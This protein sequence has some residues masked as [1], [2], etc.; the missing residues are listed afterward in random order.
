MRAEAPPPQPPP[1]T[2]ED[3][4]QRQPNRREMWEPKPGAGHDASAETKPDGLPPANRTSALAIQH[5]RYALSAADHGSFRRAAEALRLRQ[6]TLSRCIRQ[7]EE[8][9]SVALFERSSGGVRATPAGRDFLRAA[10]SIVEQ[11]D[12]LVTTAQVAG[13]GEAGRLTIGFYTSLAA[14]NLRATLVGYAQ[15]FPEVELGLAETSRARLATALRNTVIDIA[16]VTGEG[17]LGDCQRMPLWSERILAL[18]RQDHPLASKETI[19]W[20][21]LRC[22]DIILCRQDPG[23]ELQDI[24][25]AKLVSPSDRP[26][27]VQHDVSYAS[28]KSMVGAGFGISLVTEASVE[29]KLDGLVYRDLRD[30]SGPALQAYAAYWKEDNENPALANFLKL[31]GERYP[32]T[33]TGGG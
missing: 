32:L 13:R 18:I 10:R 3:V 12:T 21:D 31:L 22:E 19:Y 26:R 27:I 11:M 16:I 9:I 1:G 15:R 23:P 29:T 24:V 20:T 28:L 4:V 33:T 7:L 6:S 17:F 5:L 8:L 25:A 14:G 30:G 2:D